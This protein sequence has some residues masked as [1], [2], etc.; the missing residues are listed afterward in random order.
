MKNTLGLR[1]VTDYVTCTGGHYEPAAL[2]FDLLLAGPIARNAAHCIIRAMGHLG[3]RY[4][5]TGTDYPSTI[6]GVL[7]EGYAV[8]E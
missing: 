6:D 7:V 3:N 2:L 1:G 8:I 4:A 5:I